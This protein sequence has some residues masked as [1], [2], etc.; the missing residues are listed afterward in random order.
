MKLNNNT[1][2]N[3]NLSCKFE[4]KHFEQ[5]DVQ[6]LAYDIFKEYSHF[7]PEKSYNFIDRMDYDIKKRQTK[8]ERINELIEENKVKIDCLDRDQAFDRLIE[9][10]NR[11]ID[12]KKRLEELKLK[13]NN[14]NNLNSILE[15]EKKRYS[16]EQW[17]SIYEQRFKK[18]IND[19]INK[20]NKLIEEKAYIEEQKQL[21]LNKELEIN[22]INNKLKYSNK[23]D[24]LIKFDNFSNKNKIDI[25]ASVNRM[26]ADAERRR[27]KVNQKQFKEEDNIVKGKVKDDNTINSKEEATAEDFKPKNKYKKFKYKFLSESEKSEDEDNFEFNK[28]LNKNSSKNKNN[29]KRKNQISNRKNNNTI[30]NKKIESNLNNNNNDTNNEN[31]DINDKSKNNINIIKN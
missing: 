21:E 2:L 11:R 25:Q 30:K 18:F 26:Y 4:G 9:D 31:Y 12:A 8:E 5:Y 22:N 3:S 7:K 17:N 6:N 24:G 15:N 10:A 19:K 23:L 14:S 16:S 20:I 28:Y 29:F 27:L 1:S 13:I